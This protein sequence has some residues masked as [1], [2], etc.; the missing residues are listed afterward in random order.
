MAQTAHAVADFAV[1]HP[2]PFHDWITGCNYIVI[3]GCADLDE[4]H[5]HAA[6]LAAADYAHTLVY[7]PDISEHTALVIAPGAW[8]RR[9]AQLPLAGREVVMA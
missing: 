7:E 3:L 9:L 4:L 6:E 1:A 8:C 5:R 2:G